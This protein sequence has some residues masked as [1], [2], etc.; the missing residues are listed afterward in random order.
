MELQLAYMRRVR[1]EARVQ[2]VEVGKV[3]AELLGGRKTRGRGDR[4][5]RRRGPEVARPDRLGADGLLGK[6]GVNVGQMK[7][8][9]GKACAGEHGN[10]HKE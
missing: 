10:E 3:I 4:E 7:A 6:M 8:R 9:G 2:A 1:W 5:T